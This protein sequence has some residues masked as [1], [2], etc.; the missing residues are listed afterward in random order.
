MPRLGLARLRKSGRVWRGNDQSTKAESRLKVLKRWLNFSKEILESIQRQKLPNSPVSPP[1]APEKVRFVYDRRPDLIKQVF[2]DEIS[3]YRAGQITRAEPDLWKPMKRTRFYVSFVAG[4]RC[5]EKRAAEVSQELAR[6]HCET[7]FKCGD[8]GFTKRSQ[9][10]G[11]LQLAFHTQF[12][13]G[14]R[15]RFGI[16]VRDSAGPTTEIT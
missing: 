16:P 13:I 3:L 1:E 7:T 5:S 14:Q 9:L 6:A 10:P 11:R 2:V 12:V 15:D 8:K 4:A